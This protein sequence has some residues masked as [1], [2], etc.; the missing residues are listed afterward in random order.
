MADTSGWITLKSLVEEFLFEG[1]FD[2][3]LYKQFMHYAI[4]GMRDLH[5]FHVD[6]V[7]TI[8]VTM[9]DLGLISLPSDYINL[10][11]LSVDH[12]GKLW[13]L[14]RRDDIIPTTTEVSG[15]AT[16]DGNIG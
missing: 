3:S 2:R 15:D 10:V 8:K 9:N 1:E 4:T 7:K 14:T 16:Q 5:Q 13:P 6:S 12:E 11:R